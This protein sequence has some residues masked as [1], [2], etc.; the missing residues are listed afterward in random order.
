MSWLYRRIGDVFKGKIV[1]DTS[2]FPSFLYLLSRNAQLHVSV[3]HLVRDS[4]GVVNS[5][6]NRP[7][8]DKARERSWWNV[9]SAELN[10]RNPLRWSTVWTEWNYI[11]QKLWGG[12]KNYYRLKYEDFCRQPRTSIENALHSLDIEER[13]VWKDEATIHLPLQH[14]V[15]GNPNR[16]ES[17][18]THIETHDEWKQSLGFPMKAIATSLTLPLL[19][20]Y[21]YRLAP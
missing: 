1:V 21:G 12:H 14:A 2:K 10:F 7:L 19:I 4:R 11:I 15:K 13:P 6:W 16:F 3:L 5:W 8:E 20:Q 18:A 17:G 9:S